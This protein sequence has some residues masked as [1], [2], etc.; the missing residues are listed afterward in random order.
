M[1][2]FEETPSG[3]LVPKGTVDGLAN[4]VSGLGMSSSKRSH[5][6]FAYDLLNSFAE[7]DAAYQTNWIARGIVDIPAGDMTREWR[8]IKSD[9]SEEIQQEEKRIGLQLASA[10][11]FS[12][13][14]LFGGAG[15]LMLTNQDLG[16]PLDIT[17]IKK[18][19]FVDRV[20]LEP[21]IKESAAPSN[22]LWK[23]SKHTGMKVAFTLHFKK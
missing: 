5:N 18:G 3:V 10:E 11:A 8:T 17:K 13:A 12:W 7:L 19:D 14:R 21:I 15:I 20:T 9:K 6:Q 2:Q 22:G 16:K 4:V 23:E 1:T